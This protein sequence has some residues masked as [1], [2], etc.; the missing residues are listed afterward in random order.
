MNHIAQG[1]NLSRVKRPSSEGD[2]P[3]AGDPDFHVILRH[4]LERVS[5]GAQGHRL[6]AL[7]RKAFVL[8]RHQ[9]FEC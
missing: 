6:P 5:R 9:V 8:F 2:T 3:I 7:I 4:S 1:D